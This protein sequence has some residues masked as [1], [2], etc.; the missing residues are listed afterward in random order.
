[1]FLI[2]GFFRWSI[3]ITLLVAAA[4]FAPAAAFEVEIKEVA[5][6]LFVHSGVHED[7]ARNNQGDIANIGF[8]VGEEA[9]A[10]IDTGGSFLIGS[11]LRAAIRQKTD[12][13]IRYVI[14]THVHPDHIFGAAAFAQDNP[15]FIGHKNLQ[16]A[17]AA[18]GE[19]YLRRLKEDLLG[20]KLSAG[21]KIPRITRLVAPGEDL[22][23]DL[24]NRRLTL[25]AY[26]VAHT[27]NDLTVFDQSSGSLWLSDL[28]F[29]QRIPR[30]DGS[31]TGWIKTLGE[32]A[33]QDVR[34]AIPGHGPIDAKWPETL[35]KQRNYLEVIV[36]DVRRILKQG[37]SLQ[38]ATKTVGWDMQSQWEL[39][40]E[41]HPGNV[42]AAFVE[43]EW[44]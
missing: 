6:G 7:I 36:R 24:G 19:F 15:E 3:A 8:I 35:N 1:M 4:G 29:R 31:I 27:D 38:K 39:F 5:P 18:R 11:K 41:F 20:A 23:L 21:T 26:P 40:T 2:S 32:L 12:L 30:V 14:I 42:T 22:T 34:L 43:L 28:L 37:G 10:V 33:R 17:L 44:E 13:P 9:V 25:R 16:T